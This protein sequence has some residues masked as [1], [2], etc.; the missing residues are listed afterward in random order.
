MSEFLSK[1]SSRY[2][3]AVEPVSPNRIQH[4]LEDHGESGMTA[5][6]LWLLMPDEVVAKFTSNTDRPK[7]KK[8]KKFMRSLDELM[9]EYKPNDLLKISVECIRKDGSID[10]MAL[11]HLIDEDTAI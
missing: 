7:E 4:F 9:E 8:I 1:M 10:A 2:K 11:K 6:D 5:S 3:G